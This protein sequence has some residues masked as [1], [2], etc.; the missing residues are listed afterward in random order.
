MN[1]NMSNDKND[2]DNLIKVGVLFVG[3]MS[4]IDDIEINHPWLFEKNDKIQYNIYI[5]TWQDKNSDV[6][7]KTRLFEMSDN[8]F[9]H[10]RETFYECLKKQP[11]FYEF[12]KLDGTRS[13]D[14][15]T[16]SINHIFSQF[17]LFW[18]VS[19]FIENDNE[20]DLYI[21]MR[22]DSITKNLNI[23]NM[24]FDK[25]IFYIKNTN[26]NREKNLPSDFFWN[27]FTSDS[28]VSNLKIS[29]AQ[30]YFT[31]N[32]FSM[33]NDVFFCFNKFKISDFANIN[34]METCIRLYNKV[35]KMQYETENIKITTGGEYIWWELLQMNDSFILPIIGGFPKI[36][37]ND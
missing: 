34:F 30:L 36:Y 32:K 16:A 29:F 26:K 35:Y 9:L 18:K 22:T 14:N 25:L 6:L 3:K 19:Q 20:N 13:D 4:C 23:N 15:I 5:S 33:I 8:V 21:K 7:K 27:S 31:H 28:N 11:S 10:D 37:T 12:C 1:S 2:N 24:I 17:Y